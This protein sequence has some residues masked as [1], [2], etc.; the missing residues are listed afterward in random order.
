ME[1]IELVRSKNTRYSFEIVEEN[2]EN[3]AIRE[4]AVNIRRLKKS[5]L[6]KLNPKWDETQS[7]EVLKYYQN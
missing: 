6:T 1:E 4:K 7:P 5:N 2:L 3:G